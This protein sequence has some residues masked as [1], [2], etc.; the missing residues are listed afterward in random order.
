MSFPY[1]VDDKVLS[2]SDYVMCE[3]ISFK[4]KNIN[5][6]IDE[7]FKNKKW[8]IFKKDLHYTFLKIKEDLYCVTFIESSG[9]IS[10]SRAIKPSIDISLIGNLEYMDEVFKDDRHETRNILKFFGIIFWVLVEGIKKYN[11][12]KFRFDPANEALSLAYDKMVKNKYLLK[13]LEEVGFNYAGDNTF[14]K[15]SKI[16]N[17]EN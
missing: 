12:K 6:G 11:L 17:G 10:F 2:F 16:T 9:N 7:E 13:E 4:N 8:F 14:K 15:N 1:F 3:P 5:Y